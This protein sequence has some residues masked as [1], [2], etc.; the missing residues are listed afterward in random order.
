MNINGRDYY[1][2]AGRQKY[3]TILSGEVKI[4][5]KEML[6]KEL[7]VQ[8]RGDDKTY[9][10]I[11]HDNFF[12]KIE[13]KMFEFDPQKPEEYEKSGI[14]CVNTYQRTD[15]VKRGEEARNEIRVADLRRGVKWIEQ[16]PHINRLLDNLFVS[17]VRKEYYINWLATALIT[18]RKNRTAVVLRG[19]QGTGK[20][21]LWEQIIEYAVGYDY[22]ATI[23]NDDLRTNF[24][25]ALESKLFILANEVKGDFRDGNNMYEKLKMY[26]TDDELRIE[27]KRVDSRKVRNYFNVMITSNHTTPLQIQHGD[28]R[29]TVYETSDKKIKE[30]AE[31]EFGETIEQYVRGIKEERD[32]F[33]HDLLLYDYDQQK[34][35]QCQDT[36]EKERIYRAS[37][38]KS[39]IF[40]YKVKTLDYDF[41]TND[42][43]EIAEGMGNESFWA[44]ADRSGVPNIE[45]D[46]AATIEYVGNDMMQMIRDGG[47]ALNNHLFFFFAIFTGETSPQK[48][49]TA[50]TAHFGTSR[51]IKLADSRK[52]VRVRYVDAK[53]DEIPF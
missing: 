39:E 48:I 31:E 46:Q 28:R 21:L 25:S 6:R 22:C 40:A 53:I 30:V 42:I 23:G 2:D 11:L 38:P 43:V 5:E 8:C 7:Y 12:E 16:Y 10:N 52:N 45:G 33:I 49:G 20:G 50:L 19:A 37:V 27:Q 47:K 36:D 9:K 51:S 4:V 1:Y 44:L 3:V 18:R 35:A 32:N 15:V 24:N 41:F 29:Y 26:V 34:A 14:S 13:L 17:A